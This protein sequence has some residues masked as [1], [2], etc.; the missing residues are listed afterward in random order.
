MLLPTC[1]GIQCDL[2]GAQHKYNF[3]YYSFDFYDCTL[4][5][6]LSIQI[7]APSIVPNCDVCDTCFTG[8][9]TTIVQNYK[10]KANGLNCDFTGVNLLGEFNHI[11][12]TAINVSS[13]QV[14]IVCND[15]DATFIGNAKDGVAC[16]CGSNNVS[17]ALNVDAD[18]KFVE[19][20]IC[21]DEYLKLAD[22][23]RG[24]K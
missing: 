6:N 15:C 24:Q 4:T 2:C 16:K 18:P 7:G 17:A 22:K 21:N 14:E 19:V 1:D 5:P 13:D 11:D 23:I 10:A 20:Y 9:S 3:K 8:I 12:V